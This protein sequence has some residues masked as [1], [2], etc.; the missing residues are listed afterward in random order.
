MA[1]RG[2]FY[3]NT[4]WLHVLFYIL[5]EGRYAQNLSVPTF[6][7]FLFIFSA[8]CTTITS[9]TWGCADDNK[10]SI[11]SSKTSCL[12]PTW[13]AGLWSLRVLYWILFLPP[14][15][16]NIQQNALK[17]RTFSFLAVNYLDSSHV[18]VFCAKF[19]DIIPHCEESAFNLLT[20]HTIQIFAGKVFV[21]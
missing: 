9:S 19:L 5:S 8:I 20:L 14:S 10:R 15:C 12:R 18:I 2:V 11:S 21:G 6:W 16:C 13:L 1:L 4:L 7:C 3:E 17:I